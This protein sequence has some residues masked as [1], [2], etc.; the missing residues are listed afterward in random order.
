MSRGMIDCQIPPSTGTFVLFRK[1]LICKLV[2]RF[3]ISS[4]VGLPCTLRF[5]EA[6]G[7]WLRY[8]RLRIP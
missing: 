5:N 6:Y 8:G 7:I 4:E 3:G 2:S 1:F